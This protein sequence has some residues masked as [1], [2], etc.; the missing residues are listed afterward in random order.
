MGTLCD[1]MFFKYSFY[2]EQPQAF[3]KQTVGRLGGVGI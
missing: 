2:R 1:L 3:L